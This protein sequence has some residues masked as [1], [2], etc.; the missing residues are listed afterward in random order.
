M[1]HDNAGRSQT[2]GKLET[3]VDPGPCVDAKLEAFIDRE[4]RL[5]VKIVEAIRRLAPRAIILEHLEADTF[6]PQ[7]KR[8]LGVD[9]DASRV[10]EEYNASVSAAARRAGAVAVDFNRP[11]TRDTVSLCRYTGLCPSEP[12]LEPDG[13]PSDAGYAKIA[14]LDLKALVRS[15]RARQ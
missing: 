11:F 12:G 10:F 13:H 7:I 3:P 2:G 1:F 6:T 15:A 5:H 9:Y 4:V 14:D 8:L